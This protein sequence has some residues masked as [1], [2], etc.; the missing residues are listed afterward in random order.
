VIDYGDGQPVSLSGPWVAVVAV[1]GVAMIDCVPWSGVTQ[2]SW[3][4]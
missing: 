2:D 4:W 1:A 3:A